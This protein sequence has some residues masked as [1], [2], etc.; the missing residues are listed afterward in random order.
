M[1]LLVLGGSGCTSHHA[2]RA[3]RPGSAAVAISKVLA[4]EQGGPFG[5]FPR[6]PGSE[7]CLVDE[8]GLALRKIHAQCSTPVV[9]PPGRGGQALVSLTQTWP[10]RLFHYAGSAKRPQRHSW[11]FT[12][13]ATGRVIAD[14]SSGDFPPQWA[15]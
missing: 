14:G 3:L 4:S 9:F 5:S 1:V 6:H 7:S 8:G 13:L 2:R 12:L 10:W 11:R 15:R